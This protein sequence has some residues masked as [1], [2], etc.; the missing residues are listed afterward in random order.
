[1]CSRAEDGWR[2]FSCQVSSGGRSQGVFANI[3]RFREAE[4]D[5]DKHDGVYDC[6]EFENPWDKINDIFYAEQ[7]GIGVNY[8]SIR[9]IDPGGLQ[10]SVPYDL[11][12]SSGP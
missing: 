2:T 11:R 1:M 9:N 4:E 8:I 7:T 10:R 5:D 3:Q 12:S 6:C